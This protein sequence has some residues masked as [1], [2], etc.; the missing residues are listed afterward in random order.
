MYDNTRL[1][2]MLEGVP[3]QQVPAK[4]SSTP[5]TLPHLI[6]WADGKPKDDFY[7][8]NSLYVCFLGLYFTESGALGSA[9]ERPFTNAINNL[10]TNV[11][12]GLAR[13]IVKRVAE[14]LPHTFGAALDRARKLQAE[15]QS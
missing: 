6:N 14:P 13:L 2:D 4:P 12:E 5:F 7:D 1:A 8:W 11:G 15:W 9:F 3:A 10:H